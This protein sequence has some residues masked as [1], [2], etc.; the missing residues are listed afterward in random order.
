MSSDIT[1]K[2]LAKILGVSPSTIS[3]SLNNHPDIS[4]ETKAM[5]LDMAKKLNYQP[6]VTAQKLRSQKTKTIGVIIPDIVHFFFSTVVSGIEEAADA[7]GYRIMFCR[8]AESIEKEKYYTQS[9][10]SHRVD[11]LLVSMSKETDHYEH[12]MHVIEKKVPI[13]FFDRKMKG[14]DITNVVVD[15][16]K[17]AKKAVQHLIDQGCKK[18]AHI[19][20]PQLLSIG[21]DRLRGYK[22][23]LKENN[24]SVHKN[25]IIK[26]YG[27]TKEG[28]YHAAKVLMKLPDPPDAIF[29]CNDMVAFGVLQTLK[30]MNIKIPQDVALV[31][32]SDW[33][34]AELTEPSLTSVS[35]PGFLMGKVA[36][37]KLIEEM[38]AK[39]DYTHETIILPTKL[40][41][42]KSS[43]KLQLQTAKQV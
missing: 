5:V 10:L 33:Q 1:L 16:Y 20:S 34:M 24:L 22:D 19:M 18:I 32:F 17:G 12:F 26:D 38:K 14:L 2:D 41:V 23:A 25:Y 28:G 30:E 40:T 6:N 31:G 35:Q 9:L 39:E 21:I 29:A 43:S 4:E 27:G 11:G 37:Q 7:E 15:D 42:R 13:V 3:R 36:T 8:S